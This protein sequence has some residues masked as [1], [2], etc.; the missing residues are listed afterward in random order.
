[1]NT[2]IESYPV[3]TEKILIKFPS[4]YLAI[5]RQPAMMERA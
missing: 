1:M 5:G 3:R 4:N 2:I